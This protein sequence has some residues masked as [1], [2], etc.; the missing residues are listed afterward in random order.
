V[1]LALARYQSDSLDAL[2]LSKVIKTEMIQIMPDR[3]LTVLRSGADVFVSLTGQVPL[4]TGDKRNRY[5]VTLEQL[6]SPTPIAGD[7]VE[8]IAF[9]LGAD[10]VPAWFAV[11]GQTHEGIVGSSDYEHLRCPPGSNKLRVRVREFEPIYAP[12]GSMSDVGDDLTGRTVYSDTVVL[13]DI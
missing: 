13:P 5:M 4:E 10:G 3:T 9:G 1:Q 12:D 8:L 6:Q 11:P 7:S 2:K